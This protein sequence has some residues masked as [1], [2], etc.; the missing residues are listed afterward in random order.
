[1]IILFSHSAVICLS[2]LSIC[3]IFTQK[4][5]VYLGLLSYVQVIFEVA[6]EKLSN[7]IFGKIF[8]KSLL[9]TSSHQS[10]SFVVQALISNTRSLEQVLLLT[11][12][13]SFLMI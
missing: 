7:E 8:E 9:E 6:S 13:F 1:M 3:T 10:G 2:Y 4:A 12:L 11:L 5:G